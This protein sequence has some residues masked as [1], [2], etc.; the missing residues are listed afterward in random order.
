MSVPQNLRHF[1]AFIRHRP[2]VLRVLQKTVF[3][4]FLFCAVRPD[5]AFQ[6]ADQG[7]HDRHCGQFS[8]AQDVI[9]DR[10]L[11]IDRCHD[12]L[13]HAFIM[14]ADKD[15]IR[16]IHKLARF[17]LIIDLSARRKSD[18]SAFRCPALLQRTEYRLAPQD[19]ACPSAVRA[20]IDMTEASVRK[21]LEIHNLKIDQLFLHRP[22][23]QR[24]LQKTLKL[25]RKNCQH[26][27]PHVFIIPA[28]HRM[29]RRSQKRI[30]PPA[31]GTGGGFGQGSA[32]ERIQPFR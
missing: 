14:P 8:A 26:T 12:P 22:G 21:L 1:H 5:C 29:D 24:V 27:Y 13:I 20:V 11:F 32:E 4:R 30:K 17:F 10:D 23:S 2:C 7:I 6:K 16:L 25:I 9:T 3:K 18:H 28:E 31:Q 19:H 15:Q